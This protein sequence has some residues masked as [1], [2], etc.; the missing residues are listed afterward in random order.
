MHYAG[1]IDVGAT[2][3]VVFNI[4]NSSE[5][6]RTCRSWVEGVGGAYDASITDDGHAK[7]DSR[8]GKHRAC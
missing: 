5:R 2:S 7:D 1:K 3:E 8:I 4:L 6:V